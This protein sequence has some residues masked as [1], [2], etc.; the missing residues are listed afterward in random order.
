MKKINLPDIPEFPSWK[1]L[2]LRDKPVIDSFLHKFP[3]GISDLTFTN[4]YCHQ[5]ARGYLLAVYNKHLLVRFGSKQ[6]NSLY[7]PIGPHPEEIIAAFIKENPEYRFIL[8]NGE[9]GKRISGPLKVEFDRGMSDYVYNTQ[10]LKL[11]K[12]EKYQ[13]KRNFVR[14]FLSYNPKVVPLEEPY[15]NECKALLK[16][17]KAGKEPLPH[18]EDEQLAAEVMLD[19]L[20][21]LNVH[22]IGIIIE[23]KI[24]A[25]AIGEQLN[26][27]SFVEHFEKGNT[28]FTGIYPF[29]LHEFAKSIPGKF[30]FLNR[31]QDL[32]IEGLRKSKLSYHPA[33]LI[34]K[35]AIA[36]K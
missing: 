10:D 13:E 4:L 18:L 17:W 12:G 19:N 34:E 27:E 28:K 21:K 24:E 6:P 26:Q 8:V 29:I 9:L 32:G 25:F 7:Q 16:I 36:A 35:C 22:G 30:T 23:N 15:R 31:E 3:P 14:R 11:L 2:E 20:K 33:F 1:E 5:R